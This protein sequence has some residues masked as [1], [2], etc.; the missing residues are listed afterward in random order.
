MGEQYT[1]AEKLEQRERELAL[2]L[3]LDR[4]RDQTVDIHQFV[5]QSVNALI[6][7][8]DAQLCVFGLVGEQARRIVPAVVHDRLEI[9]SELGQG[10]LQSAS[11]TSANMFL[12]DPHIDRSYNKPVPFS[13]SL[14]QHIEEGYDI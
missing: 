14:S 4:I 9:L 13:G 7:T 8:V 1:L 3:R 6:E 11:S 12:L 2:L 5:G 10:V